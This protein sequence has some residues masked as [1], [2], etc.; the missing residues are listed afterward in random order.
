M[1]STKANSTSVVP[2]AECPMQQPVPWSLWLEAPLDWDVD[3][4]LLPHAT[5]TAAESD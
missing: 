5:C 3:R 2:R 1:G 4:D